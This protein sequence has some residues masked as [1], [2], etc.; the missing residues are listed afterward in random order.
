[1]ATNITY[2]YGKSVI[3]ICYLFIVDVVLVTYLVRQEKV[4]YLPNFAL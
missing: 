2:R 1:L 4:R 3:A